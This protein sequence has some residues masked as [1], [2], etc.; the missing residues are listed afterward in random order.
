M[1]KC[2]MTVPLNEVTAD[3]YYVNVHLDYGLKGPKVDANP[4]GDGMYRQIRRRSGAR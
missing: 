3:M 2:T 4:G 1:S